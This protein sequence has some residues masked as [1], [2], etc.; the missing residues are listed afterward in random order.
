MLQ[1]SITEIKIP[2]KYQESPVKPVKS[3]IEN[4]D[5]PAVRKISQLE[6]NLEVV[7]SKPLLPSVPTTSF[8]FLTHWNEISS[9]PDLRYK[10]LKVC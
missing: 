9:Y 7:T 4:S 5:K 6:E 8:E 1:D 3:N 2:K 10:Y